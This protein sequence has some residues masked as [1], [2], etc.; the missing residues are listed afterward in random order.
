MATIGIFKIVSRITEFMF[1]TN[2][3]KLKYTH[4]GKILLSLE[5]FLIGSRFITHSKL[6]NNVFN[7]HSHKNRQKIIKIQ[8]ATIIVSRLLVIASFLL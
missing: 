2:V 5:F 3:Q 4:T 1:Y 8:R 7:N 6:T